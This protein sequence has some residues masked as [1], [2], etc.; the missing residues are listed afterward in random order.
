MNGNYGKTFFP[1]TGDTVYNKT[2][3]K[4]FLS[5]GNSRCHHG[6][7]AINKEVVKNKV[8]SDT[9]SATNTV[10]C[11]IGEGLGA[12]WDGKED[13]TGKGT[14]VGSYEWGDIFSSSFLNLS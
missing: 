8:F 5:S 12:T 7:L 2:K 10:K 4:Y 9:V 3:K 6:K 13:F 1:G 14:L 11:N